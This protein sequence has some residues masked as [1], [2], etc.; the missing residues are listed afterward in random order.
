MGGQGLTPSAAGGLALAVG[1]GPA[2]A[3]AGA[4][5]ILAALAL[6]GPLRGPEAG[7]ARVGSRQRGR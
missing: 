4:V 1:A 2:M 7:M 5:T 3:I 6:R